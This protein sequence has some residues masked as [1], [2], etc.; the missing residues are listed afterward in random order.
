VKFDVKK[1]VKFWQKIDRNST[2]K[3]DGS[4]YLSDF[5]IF[6]RG[7]KKMVGGVEKM[8]GGSKFWKGVE[9]MVFIVLETPPSDFDRTF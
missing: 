3:W 6:N 2:K 8:V 7:S 4:T 5:I 9:S 1:V